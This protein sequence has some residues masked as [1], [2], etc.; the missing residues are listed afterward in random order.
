MDILIAGGGAAGFMAAI[1][2]AESSHNARVIIAEKSPNVLSKVRISGGGRCNV[3]HRPVPAGDFAR[4]YP[5][6][7]RFLKKI[8]HAFG[9]EDVI[10]WFESRGVPLK[11]EP[12]GRVFPRSDNSESIIRCLTDEAARLGV[13]V[14]TRMG[15]DDWTYMSSDRKFDVVFSDG[16]RQQF[17]RLILA[18]GGFPKSSSYEWLR[19]QQLK[20]E[21][22]VPSLFTFNSPGNSITQLQGVSVP[23]AR[24]KINGTKLDWRGPL[25]ITH[26]GLSGPA[27][28]KLSAWGARVLE[29]K[30][31]RF[32]ISIHWQD[33]KSPEMLRSLWTGWRDRK[34]Q[35]M[36]V[37]QPGLEL[38]SRL[39][40]FLVS[41]AGID[42]G[43]RWADISN[44]A[45]ERLVSFTC[46]HQHLISGKT[47]FKEEFVT[48]GGI[49]LDQIDHT[50]MACKKMPGLFFAGELIDV[51]GITGGFNFQ[52]AWTTGYL[53]GISATKR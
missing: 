35:A 39:W 7:E 10:H 30:N 42:E 37:N 27:V 6:G 24:I 49:T 41:E 26:W 21:D 12:D 28:L 52:N 18:T 14:R 48:C 1:A 19:K 2:A 13:R 25:L 36:I 33:D 47:T 43:Q 4:N 34:V 11:T 46:H 38:P 50:T 40:K 5:R 17:D 53:A 31:Y 29:E 16:S 20:V 32:E 45:I 22:P 51:D 44:K 9:P 3:T 23:N 15:I 8:L